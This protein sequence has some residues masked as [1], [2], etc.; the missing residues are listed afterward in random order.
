MDELIKVK[1]YLIFL[2]IEGCFWVTSCTRP[3]IG[4]INK[5]LGIEIPLNYKLVKV[6]SD[7]FGLG[8]DADQ[9][10]I[11]QFD[12]LNCRQLE[13][14]IKNTPLYNCADI[15]QFNNLRL[16]EKL[17]ILRNLAEHKLM[18]YWIKSGTV[19]WFDGDSLFL[20]THDNVVSQLFPNKIILPNRER[21]GNHQREDGMPFY[22]VQAILD[23][24][25]R[26]LY[27]RYIH[28]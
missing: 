19:Y 2:L 22:N 16:T 18:T 20:N 25:K 3:D 1:K 21:K 7:P 8:A 13:K 10:F 4:L 14:A 27:Y 24:E 23:T 15:N 17:K 5:D 11:F 26:T 12:S 6:D 9:T 28:T